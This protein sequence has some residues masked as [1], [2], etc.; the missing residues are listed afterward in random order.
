[1]NFFCFQMF[2]LEIDESAKNIL[3]EKILFRFIFFH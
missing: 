2:V 3:I 1:M